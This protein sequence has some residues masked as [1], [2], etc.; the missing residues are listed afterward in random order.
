M[1]HK[2][3]DILPP[4]NYDTRCFIKF[5][6]GHIAPSDGGTVN[7]EYYTRADGAIE[8]AYIHEVARMLQDY[9][10]GTVGADGL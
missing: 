1:W 2:A 5:G 7:S 8:W 4:D 10:Q 9:E 3:S 6:D